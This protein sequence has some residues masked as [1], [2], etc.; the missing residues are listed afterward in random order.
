[1]S[2]RN[3]KVDAFVRR[4]NKWQGETQMLRSILLECGLDEDLKWGKP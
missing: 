3:P 4:S 2:A 1:M